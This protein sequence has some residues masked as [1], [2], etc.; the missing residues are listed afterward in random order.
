MTNESTPTRTFSIS[1]FN[2]RSIHLL[3]ILNPLF[4]LLVVYLGF[5]NPITRYPTHPVVYIMSFISLF[6]EL[7]LINILLKLN[8]VVS[9]SNSQLTYKRPNYP[10]ITININEISKV[11]NNL[12]M[13]RFEIC[14]ESPKR[15]I[16]VEHLL[17]NFTEF[18]LQLNNIT[19]GEPIRKTINLKNLYPNI[20]RDSDYEEEIR[21]RLQKNQKS[22]SRTSR[23]IIVL[24]LAIAAIVIHFTLVTS[25]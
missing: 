5:I 8:G 10:G 21:R 20:F 16:H 11:K 19:E 6:L 17:Y 24:L 7:L 2:K 9:L 3:I 15:V 23:L 18:I 12:I 25:R 22:L 14:A 1:T 4:F 13:G